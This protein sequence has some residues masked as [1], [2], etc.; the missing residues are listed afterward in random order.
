MAKMQAGLNRST[1]A[2]CQAVD[3][4]VY[5]AEERGSTGV[6][7]MQLQIVRHQELVWASNRTPNEWK[8]HSGLKQT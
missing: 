2:M 7:H 1:G 8:N 4:G 3:N 6:L 5:N